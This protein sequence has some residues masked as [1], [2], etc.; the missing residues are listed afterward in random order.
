MTSFF[1]MISPAWS[2]YHRSA[3]DGGSHDV[4][5][6]VSD[7]C[8]HGTR[9]LQA[10]QLWLLLGILVSSL[11]APWHYNHTHRIWWNRRVTKTQAGRDPQTPQCTEGTSCPFTYK[12][13]S[14]L[15]NLFLVAHVGQACRKFFLLDHFCTSQL[16]HVPPACRA[17][18]CSLF[19]AHVCF[20][21]WLQWSV[22]SLLHHS[23]TWQ[24]TPC[25]LQSLGL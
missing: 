21:T 4:H 2:I 25:L 20:Q 12:L 13:S 7:H 1:S 6:G 9:R 11:N 10:S 15:T 19:D 23:D 8:L 3:G 24:F 22:F 5:A 18:R 17:L 16:G 14:C